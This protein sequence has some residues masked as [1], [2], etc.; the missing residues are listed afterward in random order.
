VRK[1]ITK[2]ILAIDYLDKM[3]REDMGCFREPEGGKLVENLSFVRDAAGQDHIEGRDTVRGHDEQFIA[4]VIY[5]PYLP[6][7]K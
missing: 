5:V 7:S 1:D 6:A 2:C 4:Y 3:I